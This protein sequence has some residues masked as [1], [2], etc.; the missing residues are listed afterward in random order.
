VQGK[1]PERAHDAMERIMRRTVGEV[2]H[3][4]TGVPRA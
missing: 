1:H 4:W 3:V 2:E